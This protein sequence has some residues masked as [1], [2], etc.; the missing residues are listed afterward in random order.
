M[1]AASALLTMEDRNRVN[2]PEGVPRSRGEGIG[3]DDVPPEEDGC[4]KEGAV[5]EVVEELVP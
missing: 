5:L 2:I 3:G 4:Q 1:K